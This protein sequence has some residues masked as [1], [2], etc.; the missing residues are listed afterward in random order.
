[1]SGSIQ[2]IE[3]V[4]EPNFVA[5][6]WIESPDVLSSSAWGYAIEEVRLLEHVRPYT[7]NRRHVLRNIM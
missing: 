3:A 5:Y 6:Y 2:K 7:K 4:G 1:M